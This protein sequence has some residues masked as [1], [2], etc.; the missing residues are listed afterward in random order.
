MNEQQA[1]GLERRIDE[2]FDNVS[3]EEYQAAKER[4]GYDYFMNINNPRITITATPHPDG[5]ITG[6]VTETDIHGVTRNVEAWILN[7]QEEQVQ[8]ALIALGWMPPEWFDIETAPKDGT[9]F[10]GYGIRHGE[11]G[12]T[13]DT[14]TWTGCRWYGGRFMETKATP[15][16]STGFTFTHWMPLPK[17][18]GDGA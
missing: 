14:Q 12:Y 1:H 15:R 11:M 7:T 10:I 8:Q 17:G 16:Y 5:T 13:D 4:S 2:Y 6:Q 18:P 9:E 3:D